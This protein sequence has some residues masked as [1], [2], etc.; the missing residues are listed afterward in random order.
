MN[1]QIRLK[2]RPAGMP[3]PDNFEIVD[4]P[5]P[6]LRDGDVLRR[7]TYLSLDPY[8]RGRMSDAP[9]YAASVNLHDVMC[10]H[11]VSEVVESRSPDFRAGDV[12]AGYDGWQ[13]Y[14]ASNGKDLRQ[15]DPKVVPVSTAIGV[16]GMP[17]ATAYVGLFDI[18]QPKP[19][20][21]VV[22]SAASGAV[23]SI[24][25]QLA[26]IKECRAV[27]IAGSPDKCRYVVEE[28]GF[29]ACINYKT[30]DLVPALRA[31][32]PNGADIYFENV[33]GRVFAAMLQV[34]NRGARIPLCGMI[35]EYN[36]TENPGGPNLR[37]LL[38]HR[39]MIKGFIVSDHYDR[40]PAFLKEV[41]PLVRE[42]RIKYREDIIEGLEAAPSA[43]IGLFEGKN[44]GKM[45]VRVA[46]DSTLA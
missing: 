22:V 27:G 13:R 11:T 23:G 21:T 41:T 35:S 10:G 36:V 7:T 20:E 18:G 29:D 8:M 37:P 34:I 44:F 4:V 46:Q 1:R 2:S 5:M 28:L 12:V 30:D 33:G 26:K 43:L 19:G 9:S 25:G 32:C 40:F 38:V 31:A 3:T 42:G 17:G 15:L 39:A 45:L 6:S 14:A 24:V 16:L